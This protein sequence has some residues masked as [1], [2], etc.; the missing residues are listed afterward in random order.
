MKPID[1]KAFAT[2]M[3]EHLAPGPHRE[4]LSGDLLE[5]LRHGRSANWYRRQ[6]ASAVGA[7]ILTRSR[8]YALP[9]AF[10]L[11]WSM[12]YPALWRCVDRIQLVQAIFAQWTAA[13]WPY[14]SSL[15]PLSEEIIPAILFVW[16]GFLIYLM[17]STETTRKLSAFRLLR[18]LSVSLNVLFLGVLIHLGHP[19]VDINGGGFY[20]NSHLAT[21]C[22]LLALSLL[23]AIVSTLSHRRQGATSVVG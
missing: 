7:G 3:L 8:E 19:E 2:W 16:L 10:S 17:S 5:E 23:S 4:A 22:L 15:K 1:S 18:S 6:V 13:D 14:S 11:G 9:L 21:T 12:F 20:S